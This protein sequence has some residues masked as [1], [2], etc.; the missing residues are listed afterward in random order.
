MKNPTIGSC[1]CPMKDCAERGDV[2]KFAPRHTRDTGRRLAGKLYMDCPKHGRL[3][4]DGRL[5][6]WILENAKLTS[7]A[8]APPP[9]ARPEPPKPPAPAAQPAAASAPA[10]PAKKGWGFFDA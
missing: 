4:S 6:D 5:S 3:G 1:P 10:K 9:P 7:A 2:R 8:D